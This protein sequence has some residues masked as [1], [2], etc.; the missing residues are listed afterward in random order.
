MGLL[1]FQ[2]V[3]ELEGKDVNELI[4]EGMGKLAS[5][6]A[7]KV[8]PYV[9]LGLVCASTIRLA[10]LRR[11]EGGATVS[12]SHHHPQHAPPKVYSQYHNCYK[13]FNN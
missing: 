11:I 13:I 5:M 6:P 8:K 1:S 9:R 4:S 2:V 12:A 3:S 7:G 10:L